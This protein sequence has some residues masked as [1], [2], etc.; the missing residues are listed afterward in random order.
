MG[1]TAI[2]ATVPRTAR[3]GTPWH[4]RLLSD[5][6]L[7]VAALVLLAC[8]AVA[9]LRGQADWHKLPALVW[10][11]LATI[12]LALALTPVMLLRRKGDTR[13]RAL[14][15]VWVAA[16]FG[17]AALSFGMRYTNHGSF[18]FIHIISAWTLLQVPLIVVRARQHNIAKHRRAVRGMVVGALLIAGFF[19]FP[20]DRLLGHWL[21]APATTNRS[22]AM[23]PAV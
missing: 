21:F 18:S 9:L 12:G 5:R 22:A 8:V 16:M 2:E 13:H 10:A 15:Y 3:G 6:V 1:S 11:H 4:E 14:G 23:T 7:A 19:T 20:F 17:T